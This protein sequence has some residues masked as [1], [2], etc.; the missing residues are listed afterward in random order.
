MGSH[1]EL[2]SLR[3]D[4]NKFKG[5]KEG[6]DVV[7]PSAKIYSFSHLLNNEVEKLKPEFVDKKINMH[8]L[9][10]LKHTFVKNNKN[11]RNLKEYFSV[12]SNSHN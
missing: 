2:E 3:F 5:Y 4:K 12:Y 11:R 8:K 1:N 6:E 10:Q 7:L 9:C